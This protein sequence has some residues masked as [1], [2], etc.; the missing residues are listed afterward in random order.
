M[1]KTEIDKWMRHQSHVN[2]QASMPSVN[3]TLI[4]SVL[5]IVGAVILI[6]FKLTGTL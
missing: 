6:I 1:K 2:G 5:I 3:W 4:A